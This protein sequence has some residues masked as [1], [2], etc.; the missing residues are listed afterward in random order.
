MKSNKNVSIRNVRP[1][2]VMIYEFVKNI[3]CQ[4]DIPDEKLNIL[5]GKLYWY[6]DK[7]LFN[8]IDTDREIIDIQTYIK[9]T[10]KSEK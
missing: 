9:L 6:L 3:Y 4:Q 2:E 7:K 5:L 8:Y 1:D 10:Y